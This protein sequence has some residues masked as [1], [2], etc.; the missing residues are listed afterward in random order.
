MMEMTVDAHRILKRA[1]NEASIKEMRRVFPVHL[2]EE[3]IMEKYATPQERKE[4]AE[5][6]RKLFE[7]ANEKVYF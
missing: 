6:K 3:M 4:A 7:T 1:A 2:L 5:R